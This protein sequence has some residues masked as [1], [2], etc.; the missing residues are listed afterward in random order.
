MQGANILVHLTIIGNSLEGLLIY[1]RGA[2]RIQVGHTDRSRECDSENG[3]RRLRLGNGFD[4]AAGWRTYLETF[5]NRG[6]GLSIADAMQVMIQYK[7][8]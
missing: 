3:Y 6:D 8:Q 1:S 7:Q 2:V 4:R 5:G